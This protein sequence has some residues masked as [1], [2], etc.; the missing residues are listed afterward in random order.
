M[1]AGRWSRTSASLTSVRAP[2][3]P[4]F[5][6]SHAPA[7]HLGRAAFIK[8]DLGL[9]PL[10]KVSLRIP[11][12]LLPVELGRVYPQ[13]PFGVSGLSWKEICA[14]PDP[15]L[16]WDHRD[17]P[18]A[19]RCTAVDERAAWGR[20]SLLCEAVSCRQCHLQ[21]LP[22]EIHPRRQSQPAL[23]WAVLQSGAETPLFRSGVLPLLHHQEATWALET[24][25]LGLHPERT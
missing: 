16:Q 2:A 22:R 4:S 18:P 8:G 3:F 14:F 13:Q 7:A 23:A 10:G 24:G 15:P 17:L 5:A 6:R 11:P 25:G 19:R 21:A 1:P 12:T 20:K 9:S